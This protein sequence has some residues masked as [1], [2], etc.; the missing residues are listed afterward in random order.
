MVSTDPRRTLNRHRCLPLGDN[1]IPILRIRCL[2]E[3]MILPWK[4]L[5]RTFGVSAFGHKLPEALWR[6]GLSIGLNGFAGYEVT[7][8]RGKDNEGTL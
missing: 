1:G 8:F 4:K 6:R 3:V 7:I 5:E 2:F